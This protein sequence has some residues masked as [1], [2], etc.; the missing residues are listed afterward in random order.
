MIL[1]AFLVIFGCLFIGQVVIAL[2]DLPLPPSIIG[3]VVLFIALQTGVVQLATVEKLAKVLMDYLVLLVIPACI[4]IMQYLDIIRDDLWVLI[5]AVSLSTVL[6]LISTAGSYTWLR[7]LQ[8]SHQQKR[9]KA[10]A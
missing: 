6:V 8:K 1:K 7:K 4:S 10:G 5:V 3:L 2:T 9:T